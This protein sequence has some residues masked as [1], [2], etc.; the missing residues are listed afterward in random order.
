M[1]ERVL[2]V[3]DGPRKRQLLIDTLTNAGFKVTAVTGIAKARAALNDAAEEFCG[4]VIEE[5]IAGGKGLQLVRETRIKRGQLPVVVVTRDGNWRSYAEA[6]GMGVA[7]YLPQP[8]V[9]ARL[10]AALEEAM[11]LPQPQSKNRN[12]GPARRRTQG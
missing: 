8:L 11:E 2:I 3:E 7:A 5:S 9:P 1:S 10:V 12:G 6:M 4:V